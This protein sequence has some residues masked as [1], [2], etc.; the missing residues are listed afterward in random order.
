METAGRKF[1][2]LM[3]SL[4]W[5]S[6]ATASR[7]S[8]GNGVPLSRD[9]LTAEVQWPRAPTA[10]PRHSSLLPCDVF[11]GSCPHQEQFRASSSSDLHA[12]DEPASLSALPHLSFSFLELVTRQVPHPRQSTLEHGRSCPNAFPMRR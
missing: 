4:A 8:S 5:R 10:T 1:R 7:R 2:S 3:K 12:S 9:R 11:G 6:R